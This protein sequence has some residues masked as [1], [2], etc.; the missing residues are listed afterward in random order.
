VLHD[1]LIVFATLYALVPKVAVPTYTVNQNTFQSLH[2]A[3][4]FDGFLRLFVVLG[5]NQ[6]LQNAVTWLD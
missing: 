6:L 4:K 3:T 1:V 5:V 2:F